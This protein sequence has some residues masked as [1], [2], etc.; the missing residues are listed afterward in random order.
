MSSI[1]PKLNFTDYRNVLTL[2]KRNQPFI[3]ER[4]QGWEKNRDELIDKFC[5]STHEIDVQ[6][7]L[8]NSYG[9]NEA[10]PLHMKYSEY[11]NKLSE[12][13]DDPNYCYSIV[14]EIQRSHPELSNFCI[15]KFIPH[16]WKIKKYFYIMF[17]HS[18]RGRFSNL[19]FDA[20]DNC[21]F[22]L[23]GQKEFY[24]SPP[25][26]DLYH[27]EGAWTS[28]GLFSKVG[29]AFDKSND[30]KFKNIDKLRDRIQKVVVNEGEMIYLP[31]GWWHQVSSMDRSNINVNFWWTSIKK[32]LKFPR[33]S[34]RAL[35]AW[36][37]RAIALRKSLIY[38]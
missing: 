23:K 15:E 3:L 32:E 35:L 20:M 21:N 28:S 7:E 18:Y 27:A 22:Q 24:L 37:H 2:F 30:L 14:H 13:K 38:S 8:H 17:W 36:A 25:G 11:L 31:F 33:Q 12:F 19:H 34:T 10:A 1:I 6:K 9:N 26:F 29:N 16:E 4:K 5:S